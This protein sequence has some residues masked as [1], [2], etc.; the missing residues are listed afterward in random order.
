M[1][2]SSGEQMTLLY[3]ASRGYLNEAK[4]LVSS[5]SVKERDD[6]DNT[7][8]H[9]AAGA[10]HLDMVQLLLEDKYGADINAQNEHGKTPLHQAAWRGNLAIVKLLTARGAKQDIED[11]DGHLP[12]DLA[13]NKEIRA[14]LPKPTEDDLGDLG[15]SDSD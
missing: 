9:L 5:T 10:G 12:R 2:G 7:P 14:L 1:Q 8:L 11:R 13:R 6:M 4:K 15:D 3:A